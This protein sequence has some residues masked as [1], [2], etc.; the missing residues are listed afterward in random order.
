MRS[1]LT[2]LDADVLQDLQIS[3]NFAKAFATCGKCGI[4]ITDFTPI[5]IAAHTRFHGYMAAAPHSIPHQS[6]ARR[7]ED[8]PRHD[9]SG[10]L[11]I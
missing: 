6:P 2:C 1:P 7:L 9:A 4:D 11:W 10:H 8:F 3:P 5:E